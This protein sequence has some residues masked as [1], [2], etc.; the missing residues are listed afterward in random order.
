VRVNAVCPGPTGTRMIHSLENSQSGQQRGGRTALPG[1]AWSEKPFAY[2]RAWVATR[3]ATIVE[4]PDAAGRPETADRARGRHGRGVP[5]LQGSALRSTAMRWAGSRPGD[6]M[7]D[8][9]SAA[10]PVP[11]DGGASRAN[12]HALAPLMAWDGAKPL[13]C[14]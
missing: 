1:A 2:S 11:G 13:F 12:H 5:D 9:P 7:L 14:R 6:K 4:A 10:A 3:T 8:A